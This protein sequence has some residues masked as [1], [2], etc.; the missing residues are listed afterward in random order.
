MLLNTK[1]SSEEDFKK[2]SGFVIGLLNMSCLHIWFS[3]L[4]WSLDVLLRFYERHSFICALHKETKLLFDEFIF[5]LQRLYSIPFHLDM[6]FNDSI[7]EEV[8]TVEVYKKREHCQNC[9]CTRTP[10]TGSE[11]SSWLSSAPTTPTT[12]GSEASSSRTSRSSKS[13]IP[14]PISLPKRPEDKLSI[15]AGRSPQRAV[16]AG[17]PARSAK[18]H[19]KSPVKPQ[20]PPRPKSRVRDTVKLFDAKSNNCQRVG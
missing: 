6:P 12:P 8:T 15:R 16:S 10:T 2:F 1:F 13:R 11:G 7:L 14:R 5:C 4:K 9:A 17:G 20:L 19:L 18:P 3:K